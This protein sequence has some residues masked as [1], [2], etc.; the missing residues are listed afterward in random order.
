[1]LH[2][3]PGQR[4][5]DWKRT[6]VAIQ[7]RALAGPNEAMHQGH[8]RHATMACDFMGLHLGSRCTPRR[9]VAQVCNERGS[10]GR[11]AKAQGLSGDQIGPG[12]SL[13]P[14]QQAHKSKLW[15][16]F[17]EAKVAHKRAFWRTAELFINGTHICPPSS[18]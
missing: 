9:G 3:L 8:R 18:I 16:L 2:G 4:K 6:S 12:R 11:A 10:P 14:T 5:R 17:K 15:P 1:M 7:H 13:T